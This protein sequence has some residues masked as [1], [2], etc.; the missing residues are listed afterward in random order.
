M[1]FLSLWLVLVRQNQINSSELS[2][3]VNWR[4]VV[5]ITTSKKAFFIS[6]QKCLLEI[7][8]PM[9]CSWKPS[10]QRYSGLMLSWPTKRNSFPMHKSLSKSFTRPITPVNHG[11]FFTRIDYI[12]TSFNPA[13]LQ[14]PAIFKISFAISLSLEL[15]LIMSFVSTWMLIASGR[16]IIY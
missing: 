5:F 11:F 2:F 1:T 9:P 7:Y 15:L 14:L 4:T 10:S 16:L 12:K 6:L 13:T 3:L 8:L